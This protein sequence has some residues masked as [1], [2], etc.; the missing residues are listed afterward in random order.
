MK[1]IALV[2]D[3]NNWAFFNIAKNIKANL[4]KYY[5]FRIIPM[6]DIED[7]IVRLFLLTKD[8]DLVHFFWRGHVT[9]IGNYFFNQYTY[10]LGISPEEFIER[11]IKGKKITTSVYDHLF[12]DNQLD[13][14]EK[15][16]S[17]IKYYTVSSK[18]L[19]DIYNGL[20]IVNKPTMEISDGVDLNKFFPKNLNRFDSLSNRNIVIGWVG[21]SKWVENEEDFKGVNTIL[22]PAINELIEEGY[23]IE[24][25]YADKQE[26]FIPHDEMND[27]YSKIDLYICSSKIEGTP[28]PVLESM[29]CG[30]P[31]I[32][33]NVGI[34]P[35]VF[36]KKQSKLILKKRTKTE[37]KKA[38]KYIIEN[39][40]LFKELSDENIESIKQWTWE[41]KS[42]LFKKFFDMVLM[43][44]NYSINNIGD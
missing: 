33:T 30:I 32:S 14:T 29:A 5:E 41:E 18:K 24:M 11:Y 13:I 34:V 38:I 40:N 21:N 25:Y 17:S 16:F 1:K 35:E 36:G 2:V 12:L 44:E 28:N 26:R 31:I 27:Y 42:K 37:M 8:Y 39:K 10:E 20:K 23:Q 19:L 3:T 7:N 43:D 9:Y 6:A 4:S 22:K 15:I